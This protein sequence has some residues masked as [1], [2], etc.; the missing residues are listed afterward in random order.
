MNL[1][2]DSKRTDSSS[3]SRLLIIGAHTHV[4]KDK[5]AGFYDGCVLGTPV[6]L[7]GQPLPVW[8]ISKEVEFNT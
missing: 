2:I 7:T 8:A 4:R 6:T 3:V 1:T 5:N